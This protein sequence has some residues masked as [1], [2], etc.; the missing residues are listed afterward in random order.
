MTASK[1]YQNERE[2]MSAPPA[3][4]VRDSFDA[5]YAAHGPGCDR[6]P[7]ARIM[8]DA[9]DAA[10]VEI[11]EFETRTFYGIGNWETYHASVIARV[12]SAAYEAGRA[13]AMRDA[14]TQWALVITSPEDNKIIVSVPSEKAARAALPSYQRQ[15]GNGVKAAVKSRQVTPWKSADDA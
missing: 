13:S 1:P 4:A 10:G 12:I 9:L 2:A 6:E 3:K 7:N 5:R 15:R 14:E 11:S 8:L